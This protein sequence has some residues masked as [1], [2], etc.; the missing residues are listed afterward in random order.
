MLDVELTTID[1]IARRLRDFRGSVLL[2]VNLASKCGLTPQY[3]GIESL[4]RNY[5]DQGLTILGFPSDDFGGQEPGSNGEIQTFC[6]TR[7]GVSFPLFEKVSVRGDLSHP[8]Y[9]Q[10]IDAMPEAW[11]PP[12]SELR[13]K[14]ASFGYHQSKPS[15]VLWNFEKF[16]IDRQGNVIGR[17]L[18]DTS[19]DDPV[20]VAAIE[21]ALAE[22]TNLS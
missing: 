4:Y 6:Q 17:F 18:S 16:L 10:L 1:G 19:P 3:E 5:R 8:L 15:D 21:R 9:R 14:L 11:A 7:Y 12:G 22:G 13:K 20:L 2:V